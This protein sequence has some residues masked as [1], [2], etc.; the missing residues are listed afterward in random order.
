VT[1]PITYEQPAIAR[2]VERAGAGCSLA[3]AGLNSHRLRAAIGEVLG[4]RGFRESARLL[5][6]AIRAA[7]G[8][9]RAAT[10]IEAAVRGAN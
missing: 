4:N 2:R 3:L 5:S 1:I 7:G 9:Q 10:L 6:V 8:V